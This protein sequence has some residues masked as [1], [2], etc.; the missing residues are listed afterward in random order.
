M[1]AAVG[2]EELLARYALSRSWL[3]NDNR[4]GNPMR[5][6]AWMPLPHVDLSVY[7]VSDWDDAS[8]VAQGVRVAE[9]RETKHKAAQIAEGKSYPE[10][11]RTFRYLGRGEIVTRDVR[12]NGL[13]VDPDEPPPRHAVIIGWPAL[14]GN[15]KHDEATQMALAYKLSE[16][17]TYV[18]R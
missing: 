7:R 15:R 16:K 4:A 10:E 2:D 17:S 6:N 3:Y 9:E 14:T 12:A 18:A 8:I 1:A 5:P 11:K 13:D